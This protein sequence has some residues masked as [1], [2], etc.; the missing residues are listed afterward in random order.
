MLA[1]LFLMNAALAG[2]AFVGGIISIDNSDDLWY[3]DPTNG[4]TV[5]LGSSTTVLANAKKLAVGIS[6]AD[7]AKIPLSALQFST[8]DTD[9][10]GLSDALEDSIG[11]DKTKEDSDSDGYN[12][13]TEVINR[14]NPLGAGRLALNNN[15][16]SRLSGRFFLQVQ[17]RGELWFIADGKRVLITNDADPYWFKNNFAQKITEKEWQTKNA[18]IMSPEKILSSAAEAIRQNSSAASMYFTP[19]M[20]NAIEFSLADLSAN[21][22]LAWGN[23]LSG[24]KLE[25]HSEIEDI[26]ST[27]VYFQGKKNKYKIHITKQDE[28]N[29]LISML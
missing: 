17:R 6:N 16:A 1:T 5:D 18:T 20:K 19:E 27:E 15:F 4:Q 8:T 10:D 26:Y 14:Y 13:M 21:S 23:L 12:D 11:T 25:E 29:W 22:R 9:K 3:A 2:T 28:G 24:A 7:L